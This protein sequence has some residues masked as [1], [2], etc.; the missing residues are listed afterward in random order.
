MRSS[1]QERVW[2]VGDSAPTATELAAST[3]LAAIT[4]DADV[5]SSW[6]PYFLVSL[7]DAV[8]DLRQV[9]PGFRFN[10]LRVRFRATPPA[11]SAL[12]MHDPRSRTLH[13]PVYTVAGTLAHE[14]A[15]DLDRQ[16]AV[17][18]GHA[19]YRSDFV[20]RA[21]PP[22]PMTRLAASLRALTEET[23]GLRANRVE[24]PAEIFATRVDWFV[25]QALAA[26]GRSSGFLSAV[27]DEVL[28][29]HVVHPERLRTATSSSPLLTALREMAVAPASRAPTEPSLET[30]LRWAMA[31]PV[32]GAVAAAIVRDEDGRWRAPDLGGGA[33]DPGDDPRA[34]LLHLAA[35]ARARGWVAQRAQWTDPSVRPA[36]ARAALA[37]APW[38]P[39]LAERR[40]ARLRNHVL[41]TLLA[42]E[43]LPSGI[44]AYAAPLAGRARCAG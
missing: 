43:Q 17:R 31:A 21:Q 10:E 41:T 26:T 37:L 19:G 44:G 3:G 9:L 4:F 42:S 39:D 32:D 22:A 28:T 1:A 27:Q 8:A 12:A 30:L 33:C 18:Q 36:W 25:A 38:S 2:F 6:R 13:L 23:V 11:D 7:A 5:P 40:V 20:A 16:S 24:R 15:H 34:R 14:L 29:G 35:D